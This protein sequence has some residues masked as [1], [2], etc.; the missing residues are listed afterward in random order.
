MFVDTLG[1]K[2]RD[3]TQMLLLAA[4]S[5]TC[6]GDYSGGVGENPTQIRVVAGAGQAP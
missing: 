2:L 6:S 1:L 3:V 4:A 5:L